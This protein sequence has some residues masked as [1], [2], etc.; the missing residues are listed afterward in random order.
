MRM[1]GAPR[2]VTPEGVKSLPAALLPELA[3]NVRRT[4]LDAVSA[5][6]GHL[7]ASLGAVE[8]AIALLFLGL[9][10]LV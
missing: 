3:E 5:N 2:C 10:Y 1:N 9:Y 8:L 4:I 7:S 6:G